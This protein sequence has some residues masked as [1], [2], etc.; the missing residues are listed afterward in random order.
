M[1][2][3]ALC[4]ILVLSTL[5]V[6]ITTCAQNK[7]QTRQISLDILLR[8]NTVVGAWRSPSPK[9]SPDGKQLVFSSNLNNGGLVT[10]SPEGSVLKRFPARGTDPRWS[11]DG[12]WICY[13]Y[14]KNRADEIWLW[15]VANSQEIQLTN[16]GG[17]INALNWSPDSR[18]I[19]FS[20]NR[21]GNYDVWKVAVP[22]GD[23]FRLT[24]DKRYEVFPTWTPDANS[25]LYVMLDEPWINHDVIKITAEG[26]NPTTVL[27]HRDFFDYGGGRGF[28]YPFVS[29]EGKTVLF[30]SYRSG[31]INY[32]T[33][34]IDGGEPRQIAP[35]SADQS[36]ARWSPDGKFIAYMSNHNGT[37][38]LR[39]VPAA[40]GKP[41]ILMAPE[42]GVCAD[43]EWSPDGKWIS[44]TFTTPTRPKDLYIVSLASGEI[45]QLTFSMSPGEWEK[46]LFSPEKITYPSEDGLT[47]NAYLWKPSEIPPG[48]RY[49]GIIWIH[50]GPTSQ[51]EEMFQHQSQSST[52]NMH[53]YVQN[54]YVILQPNIRG[55]SGYGREFEE[56][57]NKAWG[58]EDLK[59][60]LAGA[61]YLKSLPF[62]NPNKLAV[63][64]RSYGGILTMATITN[65]PG[66]FQAAIAES[67]Y[68][69]WEEG[70]E[71]NYQL[72]EVKMWEYEIGPLKG[73][74]ELYRRLSPIHRVGNVTTPVFL[75]HGEGADNVVPDLRL[76]AEQL[77]RLHKVYRYNAY[78]NESYYVQGFENQRHEMVEKLAFL[79]Q[80]LKDKVR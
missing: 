36:G 59:D 7:K 30:P 72:P 16:L 40:G 66:V 47:I 38:D 67:G 32:W 52:V 5:F 71:R 13:I 74:E 50:G 76:F 22:S 54:G 49:P 10:V 1:K 8:L 33:A 26:Q 70:L 39:V 20:G 68:C 65:A 64:G 56:A 55:S 29:P 57:N 42:M 25:I 35:E 31:W 14:S 41:R 28:G 9:W 69:A 75:I 2:K 23:V 11:P 17:R 37:Y 12:K 46:K 51:F 45:K 3:A 19:A 21:Y 78:P 77:R 63:A 18:W 61:E 73:N 4:G 79:D 80:F 24:S 44:F 27:S 34:R 53:Y 58:V 60:V 15:S 43:A 6:P 62:V 48:E